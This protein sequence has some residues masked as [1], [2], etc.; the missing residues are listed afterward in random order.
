MKST[1]K[2]WDKD[3]LLFLRAYKL[4]HAHPELKVD[5]KHNKGIGQNLHVEEKR[6]W[7]Y[8]CPTRKHQH[9][10]DKWISLPSQHGYLKSL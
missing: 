2:T 5:K 9:C 10:C 8:N 7:K 3:L 4:V 1:L 6:N